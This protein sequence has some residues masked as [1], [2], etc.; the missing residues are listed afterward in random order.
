MIGRVID[1]LGHWGLV[2]LSTY[3]DG[4]IGVSA[5][6]Y[7]MASRIVL[8][9]RINGPAKNETGYIVDLPPNPGEQAQHILGNISWCT[10]V[11]RDGIMVVFLP[12]QA[13]ENTQQNAHILQTV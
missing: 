9:A 11:S 12:E 10:N 5:A 2:I 1:V 13:L 7:Q 4:M 8:Q 3:V 6:N